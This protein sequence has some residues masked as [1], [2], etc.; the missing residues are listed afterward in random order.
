VIW[1][2]A[3]IIRVSRKQVE[4]FHVLGLEIEAVRLVLLLFLNKEVVGSVGIFVTAGWVGSNAGIP[5]HVREVWAR[6]LM[7]WTA[8][9]AAGRNECFAAFRSRRICFLRAPMLGAKRPLGLNYW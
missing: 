3:K 7:V 6:L 8:F 4:N 5:C 1:I 2:F 9:C